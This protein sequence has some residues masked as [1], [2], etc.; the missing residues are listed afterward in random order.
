MCGSLEGGLEAGTAL[1]RPPAAHVETIVWML[2]PLIVRCASRSY[3]YSLLGWVTGMDLGQLGAPGQITDGIWVPDA[4]LEK[5]SKSPCRERNQRG[6]H[7]SLIAT[8]HAV[9]SLDIPS[10]DGCTFS[11]WMCLLQTFFFFF[12]FALP[13]LNC[14]L[15]DLYYYYFKNYL[16]LALLGLHCFVWA[17]SS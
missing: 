5:F 6:G 11:R 17:F 8:L 10:P 15:Q 1:P 12:N 13:G 3:V 14:H 16:F 9:Q 7:P 4:L 2:R